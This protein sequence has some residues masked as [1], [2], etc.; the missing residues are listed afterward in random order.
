MVMGVERVMVL[1]A[2]LMV[3]HLMGGSVPTWSRVEP[4]PET[5]D[6]PG[7]VTGTGTP[8]LLPVVVRTRPVM[9]PE[10]VIL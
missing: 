6:A 9:V 3:T 8:Q 7:A 1:A 2:P 4:P 10:E 5:E